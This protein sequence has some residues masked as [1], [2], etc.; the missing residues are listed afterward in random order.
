LGYSSKYVQT[1]KTLK[2]H[3]LGES[4][5]SEKIEGR[6]VMFEN[7]NN[8]NL[9]MGE[10]ITENTEETVEETAGQVEQIAD[11][12]PEEKVYTQA[13]YDAGIKKAVDKAVTRREAKIHK[14]Y[15]RKYGELETVLK[16]GTQKEDVTEIAGDFRRFYEEKGV[17]IPS[18]PEYS[19]KDIEIL[20]DAEAKEIIGYGLEDVTEELNRLTALGVNNMSAREKRVYTKLAEYHKVA[21]QHQELSKIGVSEEVY[22]SKEFKDFASKFTQNTPITEVYNLYN[23][24][25]PKKE[26][27]NPGSMKS[28]SAKDEVKE[29][30]TFEE[31]SK[32]SKADF[33]KNPKL[34]EAVLRSMP[35]WK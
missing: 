27:K 17:P 29:E 9:V 14:D 30:Y 13:E 7:E 10:D 34:W 33:D 1:L 25:Q 6:L 23:Q 26:F 15:Q 31:A 22:E 19:T 24:M 35:K 4:N 28:T 21:S 8:E 5:T 32:F 2:A 11:E 12:Q 3:D 16:A 20:A 18:A